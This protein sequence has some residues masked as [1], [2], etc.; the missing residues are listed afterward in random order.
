MRRP[1][2]ILKKSK[3]IQK[4]YAAEEFRSKLSV[5]P[6]N[7][8][9]NKE[10][11]LSDGKTPVRVCTMPNPMTHHGVN[12]RDDGR[13]LTCQKVSQASQCSTYAP[14]FSSQTDVIAFLSA[15]D[16]FTRRRKYPDAFALN[17]V[18]DEDLH[19]L[20][21][22]SPNVVTRFLFSAISLLEVVIRRLNRKQNVVDPSR[23][24]EA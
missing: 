24:T 19:G 12:L 5:C 7:C 11:L 16:P 6:E 14:R 23:N 22:Y 2:E 8:S 1:Y 20:R 15:E 10:I 13:L 18:L 21:S 17:W 3:Q 4:Q 9:H